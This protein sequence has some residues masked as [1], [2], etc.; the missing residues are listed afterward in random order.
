MKLK[1]AKQIK[2][3][4]SPPKCECMCTQCE[5]VPI[6]AIEIMDV[7]IQLGESCLLSKEN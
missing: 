2:K 6:A 5:L 4:P 7:S 3:I 1:K